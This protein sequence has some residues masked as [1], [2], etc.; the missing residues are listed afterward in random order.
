MPADAS[1][2][3]VPEVPLLHHRY[4]ARH[5]EVGGR[6]KARQ[7]AGFGR[8]IV[9]MYFQ[10]PCPSASALR[11]TCDVHMG[12]GV[13][14]ETK[15]LINCQMRTSAPCLSP[16]PFPPFFVAPMG[17]C[18]QQIPPSPAQSGT[19]ASNTEHHQTQ[20]PKSVFWRPSFPQCAKR[21]AKATLIGCLCI[22]SNSSAAS[23]VQCRINRQR[24]N[25]VLRQDQKTKWKHSR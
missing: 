15:W 19:H 24:G 23:C 4:C 20:E 16:P 18:G 13:G 9:Q 14:L 3:G 22:S 17:S 6:G 10:S 7:T 2:Y 25:G 12:V 8:L 1:V 5:T 21:Q 11:R